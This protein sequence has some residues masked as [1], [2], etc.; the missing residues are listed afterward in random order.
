MVVVSRVPCLAG[1]LLPV[2]RRYN[3]VEYKYV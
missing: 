3:V 1:L 2:H